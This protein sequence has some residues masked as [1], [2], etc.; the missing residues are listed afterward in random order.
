MLTKPIGTGACFASEMRG[1]CS[2]ADRAE[3]LAS[4][5]NS[6]GRASRVLVDPSLGATSATDVT[7]FGMMGH[8]LEML[9]AP[10]SPS[11]GVVGANLF[12]DKVSA[13]SAVFFCAR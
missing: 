13:P 6:N 5:V 9:G 10:S 7:G 8:L 3:A 4:M 11:G 12:L 2:G 1:K